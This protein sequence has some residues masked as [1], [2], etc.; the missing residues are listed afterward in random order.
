MVPRP[1]HLPTKKRTHSPAHTTHTEANIA[2]KPWQL[3][4]EANAK[5]REANSL[6][7]EDVEFE[8]T[9][10]PAPEITMETTKTLED[11]IRQRIRD[12]VF[13]DVERKQELPTHSMS[14]VC[15]RFEDLTVHLFGLC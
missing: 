1:S 8:T 5:K 15:E 12:D 13:D 9:M 2:E 14:C 6:L 10:K 3:S 7:E 4:G 11:L